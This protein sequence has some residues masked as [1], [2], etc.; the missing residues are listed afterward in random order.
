MPWLK[1]VHILALAAWCATLLYLPALI[2]ASAARSH[3]AAYPQPSLARELFITFATPLAL[4]AI[5][6]GT[7]L[8]LR[9]TIL[10]SWLLLKLAAVAA[11]VLCHALCG[12]LIGDLEAN[13]NPRRTRL[14]CAGI[15][16]AVTILIVI[17]LALVLGKPM[18]EAP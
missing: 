17:T 10:E 4:V 7:S 8:F 18:V 2:A 11:M 13:Q 1:I 9:D 16:M 14:A 3:G 12:A 6:S 15:G 5:V